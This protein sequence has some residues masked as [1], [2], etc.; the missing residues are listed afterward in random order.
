MKLKEI[1][2]ALADVLDESRIKFELA[3]VKR[4]VEGSPSEWERILGAKDPIT[5]VL[6]QLWSPRRDLLPKTI[7]QLKK[8]LRLIG[9]LQTMEVPWSLIYVFDSD[10]D[11]TFFRG[12]PCQPI[13]R[14]EA[15]QLPARFL[16]L[17]TIHDGWTDVT[18]YMGP[19]PSERWFDLGIIYGTEY[20][21]IIP[22]VRLKDFLVIC[23][24]GGAGYL[25]FNLSKTPPEGLVCSKEDPVEVV[26]DVVRTLDEWMA[27]QLDE[28]T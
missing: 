11:P 12:F 4:L 2:D 24:T 21:N 17:Y 15:K 18:G 19:L 27:D 1:R 10:G 22:H 13:G 25:G 7:T 9:L 16:K 20:S 23:D 8:K 14:P 6:E 26:P 3:P 5:S 28:L